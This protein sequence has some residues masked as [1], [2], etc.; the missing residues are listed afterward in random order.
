MTRHYETIAGVVTRGETFAKLTD[1]LREA[2]ECCYII[3][4][5]HATEDGHSDPVHATGWRAAGQML[6][7]V[8]A[9]VTIFAQKR[10]Q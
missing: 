10:L 8:R 7:Q 5:L 3:A 2:E 9:K 1:H 6:A 4:H